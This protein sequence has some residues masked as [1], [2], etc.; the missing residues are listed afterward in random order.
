MLAGNSLK[1]KFLVFFQLGDILF[2][3]IHTIPKINPED[4]SVC[5]GSQRKVVFEGFSVVINWTIYTDLYPDFY[6]DYFIVDV[7]T[8][9]RQVSYSTV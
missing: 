5:R 6:T 7:D 4:R 1:V 8:G 3:L 9:T 2:S